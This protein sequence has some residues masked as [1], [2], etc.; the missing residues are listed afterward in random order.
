MWHWLPVSVHKMLIKLTTRKKH[1]KSLLW[2]KAGVLEVLFFSHTLFLADSEEK[3]GWWEKVE[4]TCLKRMVLRRW[5]KDIL[6][7]L[8]VFIPSLF[9]LL[10]IPQLE[11]HI[12]WVM[13]PTTPKPHFVILSV[14]QLQLPIY[15]H[16]IFCL[17]AKDCHY[18]VFIQFIINS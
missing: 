15:Y 17:R 5:N 1:G 6:D 11:M 8:N 12:G 16:F 10:V 2:R 14:I 4:W 9:V 18:K 7:L 3:I 13:Y